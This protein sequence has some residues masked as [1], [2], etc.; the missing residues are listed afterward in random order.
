MAKKTKRKAKK[1]ARKKVKRTA[2]KK[3]SQPKYVN[4]GI[5]AVVAVLLLLVMY[6]WPAPVQPNANGG[7]TNGGGE[8]N[9]GDQIIP[10]AQP[11]QVVMPGDSSCSSN[12]QCLITY[13]KG[14]AKQCLNTKDAFEHSNTCEKSSDWVLENQDASICA[15]VDSVCTMIT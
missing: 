14:E 11:G 12:S 10:P 8:T 2:P 9:G 13:C 1:T 5:I 3:K 6:S 7:N 15:C 4:L